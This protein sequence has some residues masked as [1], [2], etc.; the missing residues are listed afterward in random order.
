MVGASKAR[1]PS[2]RTALKAGPNPVFEEAGLE[3]LVR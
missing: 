1:M 2:E 3:P